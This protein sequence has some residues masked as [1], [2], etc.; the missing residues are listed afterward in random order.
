M[1]AGSVSAVIRGIPLIREEFAPDA[2]TSGL[3]PSA[4]L[5]ADGRCIRSGMLIDLIRVNP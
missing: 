1:I 5:A 3:K 4:S 2:S